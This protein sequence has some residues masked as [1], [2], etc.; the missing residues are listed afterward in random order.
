MNVSTYDAFLAEASTSS[1]KLLAE[2]EGIGGLSAGNVSVGNATA[3]GNGLEGL[4]GIGKEKEPIHLRRREGK[5]RGGGY[6]Q[7]EVT[8]VEGH[9]YVRRALADLGI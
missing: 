3:F 2:L 8:G 4:K 9:R 1:R 7:D 6:M 5:T